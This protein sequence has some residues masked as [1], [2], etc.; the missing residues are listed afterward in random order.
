MDWEEYREMNGAC[1][2]ASKEAGIHCSECIYSSNGVLD[3]L[4]ENTNCPEWKFQ[5]EFEKK[6]D[7]QK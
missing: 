7:E 1:H 6:W 5:Q 4:C 2:K 3:E